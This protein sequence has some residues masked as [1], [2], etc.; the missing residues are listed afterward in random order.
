[1]PPLT[2]S[3]SPAGCWQPRQLVRAALATALPRRLFL[4]RGPA[5]S[6]AVCLTFDDGPHPEHTVRLLDALRDRGIPATFFVIGQEAER[7][8]DLVR[9]MVAEGHAVGHH[10]FTHSE[11]DQTSAKQLAEEVRATGELFAALLGRTSALFR[12]PKGMVTAGKLWRLWGARQTVVLWDTDPKDYARGSAA[13]VREW[14]RQHPLRGGNVVLL[15]DN[16]PYAAEVLP[17]LVEAARRSGLRF[18]TIPEWLK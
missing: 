3:L 15:H 4:V 14:L 18:T 8:P 16:H 7:H 1:M 13:E 10:S 6:G 5:H 2:P 17:D 12:P 11:P 9:R